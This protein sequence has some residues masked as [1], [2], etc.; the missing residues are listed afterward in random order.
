MGGDIVRIKNYDY[1]KY[2]SI[3]A[4]GKSGRSCGAK[5]KERYGNTTKENDND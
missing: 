5:L 3:A 4:W 2:F 1:N